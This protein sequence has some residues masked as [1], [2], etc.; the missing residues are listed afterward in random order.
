MQQAIKMS[1][2]KHWGEIE[3]DLDDQLGYIQKVNFNSIIDISMQPNS[4]VDMTGRGS[5]VELPVENLTLQTVRLIEHSKQVSAAITAGEVLPAPLS[6][7]FIPQPPEGRTLFKNQDRVIL[8]KLYLCLVNVW[9]LIQCS[10]S[11]RMYHGHKSKN[12]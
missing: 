7:T 10:F 12:E 2:V 9:K 4:E 3:E 8:E 11:N 5:I 6:D 1:K